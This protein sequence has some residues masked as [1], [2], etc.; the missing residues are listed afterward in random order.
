M[1][2]T[3]AWR[4]RQD[5]EQTRAALG[6]VTGAWRQLERFMDVGFSKFVL[7]PAGG[8]AESWEAKLAAVADGVLPLQRASSGRS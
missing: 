5:I 6:T 3:L 1:L 7:V 8:P 2:D 4:D